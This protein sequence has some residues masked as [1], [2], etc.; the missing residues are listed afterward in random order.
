[1]PQTSRELVHN[2]L[3]FNHPQRLPRQTWVLPWAECHFAEDLA[4]LRQ[5]YPDDIEVCPETLVY[6]PAARKQG[7]PFI[8][9]ISTDE[10]GCVFHS[11]HAGIIGEVKE[12]IINELADWSAYQAPYDILPENHTQARDTVNAFCADTERFVQAGACARPWER[13]QFLRGTV[14][15][16]MDLMTPD[17]GAADMIRDI[18]AYYL[19]ELEF[20]AGTDV[21][22]LFFMDDWGSQQSLLIHPDLWRR[23]FKPLYRDYCNLAHAYGKYA[24]MH[25]DGHIA[26]II[27]DLV[28][29][30]VDAL[31]S[32]L[33]TMDLTC[34]AA[35]AKGKLTFWGEIDRQHILTQDDPQVTRQAVREVADHLYDPAGGIIAQFEFGPGMVPANAFAV[36]EEWDHIMRETL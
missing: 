32:Q 8:P 30:G 21:D 12:P 6:R 4:A 5:A 24:F 29:I 18:H 1:M 35:K 23:L 14:N 7:D 20:W 27:E 15:A 28:E 13:M 16:M 10:W 17:Q 2:S 19:K 33:F 11:V 9:G 26:A 25:S 34:L 3:T 36:Y 22:A 31:N